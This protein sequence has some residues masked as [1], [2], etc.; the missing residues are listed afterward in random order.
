MR[1]GCPVSSLAVIFFVAASF[2]ATAAADATD[3][4]SV[5]K[6]GPAGGMPR[7]VPR[8]PGIAGFQNTIPVVT[9]P[10]LDVPTLLAEDAAESHGPARIGRVVPFIVNSD[11]DGSW[12]PLQDGSWLCAVRI[13][14]PGAHAMR[15]RIEPWRP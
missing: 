5:I 3:V 4:G 15:V 7:G 9:T 11:T 10:A 1:T 14:A 12:Q 13:H 6:Q 8:G 2:A